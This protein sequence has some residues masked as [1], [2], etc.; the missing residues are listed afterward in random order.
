MKQVLANTALVIM[1]Q[2]INVLNQHLALHK[3]TQSYVNYISIK[4]RLIT[5]RI[6]HRF[7]MNQ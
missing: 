4:T 7:L 2:Y 5:P 1:L 6:L 3:L